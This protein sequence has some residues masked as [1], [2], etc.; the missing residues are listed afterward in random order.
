MDAAPFEPESNHTIA[1]MARWVATRRQ[2]K[3]G[4]IHFLTTNFLH[5]IVVLSIVDA[6]QFCEYQG[7]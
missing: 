4:T 5:F 1:M 2:Y 6:S 3:F 7:R